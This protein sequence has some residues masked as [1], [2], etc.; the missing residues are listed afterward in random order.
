V[1]VSAEQ[2]GES[3]FLIL[4]INFFQYL[5]RKWLLTAVEKTTTWKTVIYLCLSSVKKPT[6]PSG[7]KKLLPILLI[8]PSIATIAQS[9]YALTFN[10]TNNYVS[11][12]TPLSNGS[13]YTKEAWVYLTTSSGAR[14]II[15]SL[16]T[17]F[18][19]N[20]GILSA[21]QAGAIVW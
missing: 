14:N 21:G 4:Q 2:P 8:L 3:L 12:S 20:S 19:I 7:M 10:G 6:D 1:R 11:I 18:W 9:N 13:S 17:P 16:N 15:S 5:N